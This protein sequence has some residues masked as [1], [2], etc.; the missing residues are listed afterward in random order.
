MLLEQRCLGCRQAGPTLCAACAGG[1]QPPPVVAIDG[2]GECRSLFAYEGPGRDLVVAFKYRD[3]RRLAPIFADALVELMG[4]VEA[5]VPVPAAPAH[6]RRR[7]YDPSVVLARA[8]GSRVGLPVVGA[9]RR[10]DAR[11]QTERRGADRRAGPRLARVND[12]PGRVALVDDVVTTGATL[13]VAAA[14]MA[15]GG[16]HAEQALTVAATPLQ[17][18]AGRDRSPTGGLEPPGL[19]ADGNGYVR[20]RLQRA[21]GA[22]RRPRSG[23]AL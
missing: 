17:A 11:P 7:G 13:A 19:P 12:G 15:P 22:R 5:L 9:L 20:S 3:G 21:P 23:P 4:A 2:V 6:R 16:W 18:G 14:V 1:L 8:L 10:V